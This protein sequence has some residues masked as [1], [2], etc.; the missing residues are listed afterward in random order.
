VLEVCV[1]SNPKLMYRVMALLAFDHACEA[2][3]KS[4]EGYKCQDSIYLA[5]KQ[6]EAAGQVMTQNASK[7]EEASLK[8]I[9]RK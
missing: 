1:Y 2:L 3:V 4:A 9:T 7:Y 5:A 8:F 6:L